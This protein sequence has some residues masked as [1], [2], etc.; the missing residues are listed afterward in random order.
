MTRHNGGP[1]GDH[2]EVLHGNHLIPRDLNGY[3]C[4]Y[5]AQL[6]LPALGLEPKRLRFAYGAASS[7]RTDRRQCCAYLSGLEDPR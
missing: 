4:R 3:V 5:T 1:M 2:R 7:R 6:R